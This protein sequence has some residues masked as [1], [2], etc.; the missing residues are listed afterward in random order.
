MSST[1][2]ANDSAN[3]AIDQFKSVLS[4]LIK[5]GWVASAAACPNCQHHPTF[6]KPPDNNWL[7]DGWARNYD[8][9]ICGCRLAA[10][11]R[12]VIEETLNP[13]VVAE[14]NEEESKVELCCKCVFSQPKKAKQSATV[15]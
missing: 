6:Y 9:H 4:V 13:N 14:K 2:V 7:W 12:I 5:E 3:D 11:Q 8:E 1:Q 10:L 15:K